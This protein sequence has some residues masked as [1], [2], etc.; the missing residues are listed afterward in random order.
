MTMTCKHWRRVGYRFYSRQDEI[1]RRFS[2]PYYRAYLMLRAREYCIAFDAALAQLL[3]K[4]SAFMSSSPQFVKAAVR[5]G[6]SNG[7]R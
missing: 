6:D 2:N 4:T 5:F 3:T 7:R 1:A